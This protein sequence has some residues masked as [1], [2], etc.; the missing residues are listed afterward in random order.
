MK[1]GVNAKLTA[2]LRYTKAVEQSLNLVSG[3]SLASFG[4]ALP[5][6]L[7]WA[8]VL[9]PEIIN[10]QY[11]LRSYDGSQIA[12]GSDTSDNEFLMSVIQY[13][14]GSTVATVA[15]ELQNPPYFQA[16]FQGMATRPLS[17]DLDSWQTVTQ[18]Y[19][20]GDGT[21]YGMQQ[22]FTLTGTLGSTGWKQI[23]SATTNAN[24]YTTNAGFTASAK[25]LG[26]S[27][28]AS[29][30]YAMKITSQTSLQSS[31]GFYYKPAGV[32]RVRRLCFDHVRGPFDSRPEQRCRRVQCSLDQRRHP[33]SP[34]AQTMVSLLSLLSHQHNNHHQEA[35]SRESR[36]EHVY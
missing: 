10:S 29:V 31:L 26:F 22:L 7:G 33:K 11:E 14:S 2:G 19:L 27:T 24:T 23:E 4:D 36:R 18:N 3:Y 5:G 32:R 25:L 20:Q 21:S 17:T 13:G 28:S 8:L 35:L 30:N 6:D 15:Y 1:M 9:K 12:Y 16:L 34:K